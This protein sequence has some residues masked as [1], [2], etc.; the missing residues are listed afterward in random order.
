MEAQ[1]YQKNS[2][3]RM[4]ASQEDQGAIRDVVNLSLDWNIDAV[5]LASGIR[6]GVI[7]GEAQVWCDVPGRRVNQ[8]PSLS[9]GGCTHL[10]HRK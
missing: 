8:W 10:G 1:W 9:P 7:N 6:V 3:E 5:G 4:L 2:Q